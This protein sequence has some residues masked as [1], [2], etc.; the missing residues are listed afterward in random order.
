VLISAQIGPNTHPSIEGSIYAR[1]QRRL[2]ELD[3]D[4]NEVRV[5]EDAGCLA[6]L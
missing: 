3:E 2:D 5:E 6:S 4:R 1:L